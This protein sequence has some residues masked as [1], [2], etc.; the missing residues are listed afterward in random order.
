MEFCG[1]PNTEPVEAQSVRDGRVRYAEEEPVMPYGVFFF[2]SLFCCFSSLC[3]PGNGTHSYSAR[4]LVSQP[5]GTRLKRKATFLS[6][7]SFFSPPVLRYG[8]S[9]RA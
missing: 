1:S 9:V 4:V 2:F 7:D 3:F 5:L 8:F 6:F